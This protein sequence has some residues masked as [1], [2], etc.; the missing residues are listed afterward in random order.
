MA[1]INSIKKAVTIVVPIYSDWGALRGC[2]ESLK[3]SLVTGHKVLLINDCGPDADEMERKI[4]KAITD[5]K[6]FEYH[7]NPKNLG[8]VGTCNRAVFELDK[9]SSDILLLNSDTSATPGFL[10]EMIEVLYLDKSHGAVSPRSNSATHASVPMNPPKDV[11][12]SPQESYQLFIKVH[13]KLPRYYVSVDA[14]GFC[15]LTRRSL[16][17]KYGLFD[18][19]YSPGYAEETDYCMRL[20]KYGYKSLFANHAFV[21]HYRADTFTSERKAI[22]KQRNKKILFERYPDIPNLVSDFIKEIEPIESKAL[23]SIIV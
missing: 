19:V 18:E 7:R 12:I 5:F 8:F 17:M 21:F 13:K 4:K 9:T 6:N 22:L 11:K 10:E 2:I 20:R 3:N 1:K 16:I 14:P 15:L 23:D